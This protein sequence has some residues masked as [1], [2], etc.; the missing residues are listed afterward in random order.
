VWGRSLVRRLSCLTR[1]MSASH[2]LSG[3][4]PTGLELWRSGGSSDSGKVACHLYI[5]AQ[6]HIACPSMSDPMMRFSHLNSCKARP[7]I[8]VSESSQSVMR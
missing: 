4:S 6:L 7:T 8:A 5:H 2:L 3:G 1:R